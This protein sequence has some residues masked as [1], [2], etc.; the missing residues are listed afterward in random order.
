M[1]VTQKCTSKGIWQQGTVLRRRSCLQKSL[2][3][4]GMPPYSCSS[5]ICL[6]HAPFTTRH[7]SRIVYPY[8]RHTPVPLPLPLPL[9]IPMRCG[10]MRCD[11]MWSRCEIPKTASAAWRKT[12]RGTWVALLVQ[13][14]VSNMASSVLCDVRCVRDHH[15]LLL[16]SQLLKET[17]VRQVVLDKWFTLKWCVVALRCEV[18]QL[19]GGEG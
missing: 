17:R 19:V 9:Q 1:L 11:A 10:A 18:L 7:S 8:R 3:P 13:R 14:Y 6:D 12:C 5:A 16:C 15:K 2:C 4:V